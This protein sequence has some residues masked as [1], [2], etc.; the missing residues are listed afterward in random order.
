MIATPSPTATAALPS[1]SDLVEDVLERWPSTLS[2]FLKHRMACPGCPMARFQTVAEVAD[3]Y[4]LDSDALLADF[5][6][7]IAAE[8]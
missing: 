1:S 3:D 6:R 2:V 7:A 5:A 8:G 4:G